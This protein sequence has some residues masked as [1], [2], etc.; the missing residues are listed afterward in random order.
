MIKTLHQACSVQKRGDLVEDLLDIERDLDRLSDVAGIS[1]NLGRFG[2]AGGLFETAAY[3]GEVTLKGCLQHV[4][5][6]GGIL[7]ASTHALPCREVEQKTSN[8]MALLQ[9][10]RSSL[11]RQLVQIL[12]CSARNMR[13]GSAPIACVV[14]ARYILMILMSRT[15]PIG[16]ASINGCRVGSMICIAHSP[17]ASEGLKAIN[18][19]F[20]RTTLKSQV[21]TAAHYI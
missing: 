20:S 16:R 1:A 2:D 12:F 18:A 8:L 7:S 14:A 11:D 5:V 10:A 3:F 13:R 19:T 15:K 9:P 6:R 17:N 21:R 4:G